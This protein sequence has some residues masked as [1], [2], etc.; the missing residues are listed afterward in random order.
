MW[1]GQ[2]YIATEGNRELPLNALSHKEHKKQLPSS[3]QSCSTSHRSPRPPVTPQRGV[4]V[5]VGLCHG[6]R[7]PTEFVCTAAAM[8]ACGG[9]QGWQRGR[10]QR[11]TAESAG[12][13]DGV[14][15]C[16]GTTGGW[17]WHEKVPTT[18]LQPQ[19]VAA[20]D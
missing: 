1:W 14:T 10:R 4:L 18:M 15:A 8:S 7:R 5:V 17:D 2:L 20:A 3:R 6:K 19:L 12:R 9:G 11:L 16:D 13:R